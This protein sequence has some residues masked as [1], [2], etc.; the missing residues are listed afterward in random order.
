MRVHRGNSDVIQTFEIIPLG[1][2][3]AWA[4]AESN[5]LEGIENINDKAERSSYY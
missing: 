5:D 4:W 2:K 3:G 1:N